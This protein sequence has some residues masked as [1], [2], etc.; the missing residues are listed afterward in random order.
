MNGLESLMGGM[1]PQPQPQRQPQPQPQTQQ[2]QRM[3]PSAP[4]QQAPLRSGIAANPPRPQQPSPAVM[5]SALSLVDDDVE[6]LDVNTRIEL[7]NREILNLIKS[8]ERDKQMAQN[9]MPSTIKEQDEAA[10]AQMGIASLGGP[11]MSAMMRGGG[12]IGYQAGGD[13]EN[14]PFVGPTKSMV[15]PD[16]ESFL[17]FYK[18]YQNALEKGDPQVIARAKGALE[19][20][21]PATRATA[22]R[23][24]NDYPQKAMGGQIRGYA[25]GGDVLSPEEQAAKD[26]AE[27]E[28]MLLEMTG[29][30]LPV[31][32]SE[33]SEFQDILRM[34]D[35]ER[36]GELRGEQS[37]LLKLAKADI[38]ANDP[39][40]A[41]KQAE[42]LYDASMASAMAAQ[43]QREQDLQDLRKARTDRFSEDRE[44]DLRR[45]KGLAAF[46]KKGWGGY[47]EGSMGVEEE[48]SA[49]R[50]QAATDNFKDQG[51]IVEYLTEQG[52]KRID[53][54][55]TAREAARAARSGNITAAANMVNSAVVSEDNKVK[56]AQSELASR[57]S[58]QTQIKVAETQTQATKDTDRQRYREA[59][60]ASNQDSGRSR[61]EL[62]VEADERYNS[63]AAGIA[64]QSRAAGLDAATTEAVY[65]AFLDTIAGYNS[66]LGGIRSPEAQAYQA[67][68]AAGKKRIEDALIA[69]LAN[70]YSRV[71]SALG[72]SPSGQTALPTPTNTVLP[73]PAN[74][75]DLVVG[76][77][78]YD[79]NGRVGVWNGSRFVPVN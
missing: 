18:L 37:E 10:L 43:A 13:V 69:T 58:A 63:I 44:K 68:D 2:P 76:Q 77:Q 4:P 39:N 19:N 1:P 59:Y 27:Y 53:A 79:P 15:D 5:A 16:V 46:A 78:Y 9:P 52:V 47:S 38:E 22:M 55:Q 72:G 7:K 25:P 36:A 42:A 17:Y 45:K 33:E 65:D 54:V 21:S 51:A 73:S 26:A 28:E 11:D 30:D 66:V 35:T 62:L 3:A 70:Q 49:G 41:Q 74:S 32:T 14:K 48:F 64:A 34:M 23:M 71:S 20:F 56:A 12:I 40:E 6:N 57:R 75:D 60:A 29:E 61:N 24:L 67:A 8:I 31:T 50:L